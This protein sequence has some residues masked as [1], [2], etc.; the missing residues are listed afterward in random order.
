MLKVF[1]SNHAGTEVNRLHHA[2]SRHNTEQRVEVRFIRD[3]SSIQ[4][5]R[6]GLGTIHLKMNSLK[7]NMC[8]CE[9]KQI[10]KNI[11]HVQKKTK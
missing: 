7:G 10:I 8:K 1:F 2:S 6:E 3:V 9:H 4:R 5:N 11:R